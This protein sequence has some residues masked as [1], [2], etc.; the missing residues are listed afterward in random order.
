MTVLTGL[1]KI[2]IAGNDFSGD[3]SSC[4]IKGANGVLDT[5]S[6]DLVGMKR[7]I[8]RQGGEIAYNVF[9]NKTG[10]HSLLSAAPVAA[11]IMIPFPGTALGDFVAMLTAMQI[12]Y[13]LAVGQDLG[14]SF[15]VAAQASEGYP[16]EW[17]LMATAGKR[18][19][20]SA[21]AS[22][23]G[24][25]LGIPNGVAAVAITSVSVANPTHIVTTTAHGL[26]TG[27]SVVIAGT[28]TTPS[29]NNEYTVTFVSAT[30]FTIPVNVTVGAG[31]AGTVQR[32]SHRG[33]GAQSQ[34]FSVVGTSVTVKL[35]DAHENIAGS[36]TDLT[37]GGFAAVTSGTGHSAERIGSAAGIIRRYLRIATTG[38]F[39]SG[40]F[41]VGVATKEG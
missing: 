27:D 6:L 8:G 23:T 7:I 3:A 13:P 33:W 4:S 20:G 5:S 36:F 28:T 17:G 2:F 14:A 15:S 41:S 29:I 40:V 22:G 12:D 25:D 16:L 35:Q 18:T 32:T 37:G 34:V 39:S 21:T 11:N 10:A 19:D 24:I 30:E 26:Q 9:M 31:A 38:T 1:S